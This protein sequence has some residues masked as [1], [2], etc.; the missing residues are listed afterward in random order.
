M[1]VLTQG[2]LPIG[3]AKPTPLNPDALNDYQNLGVKMAGPA[4]NL[5]F[6]LLAFGS[7]LLLA[8]I[9]EHK[10]M[11]YNL[12][13]GLIFVNALLVLLNLLPLPGGDGA[14]LV[15]F[16]LPQPLKNWWD[17]AC[18]YGLGFVIMIALMAGLYF[19]YI[20]IQPFYELFD[21]LQYA[22]QDA[23]LWVRIRS[24]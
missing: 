11:T 13:Y 19:Q 3:S 23:F 16:V 9:I 5:L 6:G 7:L 21:H 24:L 1:L 17:L 15:R 20:D 4:A 12:L 18:R 22:V 8:P 2:R 14:E 10:A